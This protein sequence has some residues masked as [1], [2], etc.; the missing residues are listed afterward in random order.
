MKNLA[1]VALVSSLFLLAVPA[2]AATRTVTLAVEN[3]T[4]P[5]CPI[6]VKKALNG[7]NGVDKTVVN[8]ERREAIVTYDDTK[9]G[10]EALIRATTN[11]G[12]P[13]R[14]QTK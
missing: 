7:V 11:A 8:F 3:M 2:S 9:T 10:P 12:Y 6:T 13:A 1:F 5:V 14:V 4:C